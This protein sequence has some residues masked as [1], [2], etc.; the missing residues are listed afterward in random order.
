MRD[1]TIQLLTMI[2]EGLI[3]AETVAKMCLKYMSEYDVADMMRCND[4]IVDDVEEEI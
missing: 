1:Q 3:S 4:I 2:D